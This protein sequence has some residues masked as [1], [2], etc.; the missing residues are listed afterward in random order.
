[1]NPDR[2]DA[3]LRDFTV[4]V[5]PTETKAACVAASK[6]ALQTKKPSR[7]RCLRTLL[8][9]QISYTAR[10]WRLVSFWLVWGVSLFLCLMTFFFDTANRMAAVGIVTAPVFTLPA[11]LTAVQR[12]C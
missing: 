11:I 6:A 2:L 10:P 4:D 1:M 7:A 12:V 9:V 8:R 3:L 5:P